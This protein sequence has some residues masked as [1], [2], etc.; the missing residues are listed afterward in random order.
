MLL[1]LGHVS[2]EWIPLRSFISGHDHQRVTQHWKMN[3]L[4]APSWII[5]CTF[6]GKYVDN[7]QR[8]WHE[9][10]FLT[11]QYEFPFQKRTS[12]FNAPSSDSNGSVVSVKST[13]C[14]HFSFF[15]LCSFAGTWS[16]WPRSTWRRTTSGTG[17][18]SWRTPRR[19]TNCATSRSTRTKRKRRKIKLSITFNKPSTRRVSCLF[20]LLL[21]VAF[22]SRTELRLFGV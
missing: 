14:L 9:M 3:W 11:G 13:T 10:T 2:V 16:I 20:F 8:L 22:V 7:K 18:G 15:A 19:A 4:K 6:T 17:C 21:L 1:V 12:V 5:F